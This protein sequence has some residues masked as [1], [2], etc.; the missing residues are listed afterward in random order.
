M[1]YLQDQQEEIQDLIGEEN[2]ISCENQKHGP[3]IEND[4]VVYGYIRQSHYKVVLS[5][6]PK[7]VIGICRG[8]EE[9]DCPLKKT[10]PTS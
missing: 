6:R 7:A 3:L 2:G 1:R 10:L 5:R 8:D 4:H 9:S